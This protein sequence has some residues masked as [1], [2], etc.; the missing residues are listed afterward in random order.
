MTSGRP[1][2][3][4]YAA[5][6]E[7]YV[8]RVGDVPIVST[9]T[10][11]VGEL[12]ELLD[13]LGPAGGSHR[14]APGKWSVGE[15]IGHLADAERI[16]G[17][18]ATCIA[19]GERAALPGFEQDDYVAEGQFELRTIDSLQGE[20]ELLRG[21]NV[22]M[23]KGLTDDRWRREGTASGASISVRAL[24]WILAGHVDHHLDVLRER[25]GGAFR[26]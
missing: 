24:A 10:D 18:R 13:G 26:T 5:F 14:Y 7:R 12:R 9:L 25:Y 22:A 21:A 23:F 4:E 16:F 3:E 2:P 15:V 11:Q 6:Y 20:F 8:S 19:R 17:M 1:Q